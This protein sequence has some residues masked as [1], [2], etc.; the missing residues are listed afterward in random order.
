MDREAMLDFI[1][2]RLD[3]A[4]DADIEAVYWMVLVE[5]GDA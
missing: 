5:L 2:E 4:S 3:G 1:R